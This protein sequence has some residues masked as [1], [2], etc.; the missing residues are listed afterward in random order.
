MAIDNISVNQ[1]SGYWCW[2]DSFERT[3]VRFVGR[4][5]KATRHEV[6]LATVRTGSRLAVSQLQ[7]IHSNSVVQAIAGDSGRG[8]ALITD[9]ASLALSV[10]TADCVPVLFASG[11]RTAAVHAGWR[12][13]ASGIVPSV[14]RLLV[15]PGQRTTAWIGPS[16]GP[17][18]YEVGRDVASRTDPGKTLAPLGSEKVRGRCNLDLGNIVI[19]QLKAAGIQDIRHVS[20]CTQC[21]PDL[22][23]S[24]RG[25]NRAPGGRNLAFI[26]REESAASE[27]A[28]NL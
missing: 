17:C 7:Q 14:A 25:E 8:D 12:G 22:L 13:I 5:P 15:S 24:Y 9:R 20:T 21:N 19:E 27:R 28:A 4:G 18:C 2:S 11:N 23:W 1:D 16:I 10:A 6:L 3:K 26:W